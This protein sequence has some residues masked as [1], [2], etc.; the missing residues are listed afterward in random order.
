MS[1]KI[2]HS[3]VIKR[4][5]DD[6]IQVQIIQTSACSACKVASLCG[7]ASRGAGKQDAESKIKLIDVF[8]TE[9]ALYQEG[10]EVTVWTSKDVAN[11]ALLLGFGAP[12]LILICVLMISLKLFSS[13]GVAAL[14][15]LASLVPYYLALWCLKDRIQ[16][17][18]TFYIEK[19]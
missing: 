9:T 2:T 7:S 15:A 14:V 10:Q 12:F 4:I 18:L 5:A 13:E 16:K 3:G 19:S 6:C 8:T 11:R 1:N 17:Q